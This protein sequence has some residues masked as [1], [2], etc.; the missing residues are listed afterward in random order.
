MKSSA[1]PA[2]GSGGAYQPQIIYSSQEPKALETAN[3]LA[4]PLS[5]T[6]IP[7]PNLH[8]H[9]RET[10][11]FTCE[12]EFQAAVGRFFAYPGELIF[13]EE[14]AEQSHKRFSTAVH[15][16]LNQTPAQN[17]AIVAHGTV[18]SLFVSRLCHIEPFPLWQRL[19]LPSF[20]VLSLPDFT[21]LRIAGDIPWFTIQIKL[22]VI[23]TISFTI[24]SL[25]V[26]CL[27]FT[28]SLMICHSHL[29]AATDWLFLDWV[30]SRAQYRMPFEYGGIGPKFEWRSDPQVIEEQASRLYQLI[31]DL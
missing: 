28:V 21:L 12:D 7:Y 27:H 16:L 19:G 23:V 26:T 11:V 9:L 4:R 24:S 8:E 31:K 15:A 2:G 30:W 25:I 18:I 3:L 14:T 20:V 1:L 6:V 29:S 17:L 10:A 13:G 22:I 5:L